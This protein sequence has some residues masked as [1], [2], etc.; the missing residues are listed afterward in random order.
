[1][2]TSPSQHSARTAAHSARRSARRRNGYPAAPKE[3][4]AQREWDE[5]VAREA[6]HQEV[7]DE[8][9]GQQVLANRKLFSEGGRDE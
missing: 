4:T 9:Q 3:S 2:S 8:S 6:M 1:M 7:I 5:L